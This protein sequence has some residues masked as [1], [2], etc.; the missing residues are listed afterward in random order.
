MNPLVANE[1]RYAASRFDLCNFGCGQNAIKW[2]KS[3]F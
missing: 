3:P 2:H 1:Q